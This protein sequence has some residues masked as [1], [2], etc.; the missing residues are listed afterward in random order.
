MPVRPEHPPI[1]SLPIVCAAISRHASLRST[2]ITPSGEIDP[3]FLDGVVPRYSAS[4]S[5]TAPSQVAAA[6]VRV[7]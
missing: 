5:G 7:D 1:I 3:A 2:R 4:F 6:P